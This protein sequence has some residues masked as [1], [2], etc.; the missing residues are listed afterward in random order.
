MGPDGGPPG[1]G[2]HRSRPFWEPDLAVGPWGGVGMGWGR[3]GRSQDVL[4]LEHPCSALRT[5]QHLGSG[6]H[7]GPSPLVTPSG[8]PHTYLLGCGNDSWLA[9]RK[10]SEGAGHRLSSMGLAALALH[11]SCP[12]FML[13][14]RPLWQHPFP[15][16]GPFGSSRI[17][18]MGTAQLLQTNQPLQRGNAERLSLCSHTHHP[19]PCCC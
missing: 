5:F 10:R 18:N 19:F 6:C 14:E 7:R 1:T 17:T 8:H 2:G 9:R 15:A 13:L 11:A 3:R 12:G 4:S 16:P